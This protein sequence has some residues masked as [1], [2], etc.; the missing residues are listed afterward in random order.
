MSF[1][2]IIIY[3]PKCARQ[4]TMKDMPCPFCDAPAETLKTTDKET[5]QKLIAQP[6]SQQL[7]AS[8]PEYKVCLYCGKKLKISVITCPNC[9]KKI[10]DYVIP[11]ENQ[12]AGQ[13][14]RQLYE[15]SASRSST[16]KV[17]LGTVLSGSFFVAGLSALADPNCVSANIGGGRALILSCRADSYGELSGKVAGFIFI[18]IGL[19]VMASFFSKQILGL[20]PKRKNSLSGEQSEIPQVMRS[21]SDGRTGFHKEVKICDKC[22]LEVP[23]SLNWCRNCAGVSFHKES[24]IF[25]KQTPAEV[26]SEEALSLAFQESAGGAP[27]NEVQQYKTCPMC[28]EEIKF[29]AK[30]CRYCQ[31]LFND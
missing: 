31:H 1:N 15:K 23:R 27:S 5:W 26:T 24:R 21:T 22:N 17:I 8:I 16:F 3:C 20:A 19:V 13:H 28:A 18:F 14:S 7:V 10:F 4:V 9:S 30:K 2:Q 12:S 25:E 6:A 11:V 29:A